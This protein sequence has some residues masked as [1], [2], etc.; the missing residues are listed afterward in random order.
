MITR[1]RGQTGEVS[2]TGD[3]VPDSS[4]NYGRSNEQVIDDLETEIRSLQQRLQQFRCCSDTISTFI[5]KTLDFNNLFFCLE[6][7]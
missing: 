1:Q 3:A 4:Q 2:H 7:C 5:L 6:F